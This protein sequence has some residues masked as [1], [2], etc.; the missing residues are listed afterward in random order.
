MRR[1]PHSVPSTKELSLAASRVPGA[2]ALRFVLAVL[3]PYMIRVASSRVES[4]GTVSGLVYAA[5]TVG[6]IAGVFVSG[7]YF[8]DNYNVDTIFR[9]TGVVTFLLA[10][11]SLV[12][13][14]WLGANGKQTGLN[15]PTSTVV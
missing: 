10:A 4:V 15:S 3:S 11:L 9:V 8:I 5:S 1:L 13:D 7:Y 14:F 12:M 6:S 2:A